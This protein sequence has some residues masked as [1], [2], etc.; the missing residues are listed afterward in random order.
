MD[1]RLQRRIQR[2]GWDLAAGDYEA[3]W[4]LQLAPAQSALMDGAALRYGERVLDV[5]CGTGLVTFA[6]ARAVGAAGEVVGVDISGQMVEAARRARE[7]LDLP[8]VE[9]ARMDAES[10]RFDDASFDVVLCSLGLMYLPD[11]E[12]A[13]REMHRVLRPGGRIA[14]TVWG[15]RAH[16]GWAALFEIVQDE[17]SSDVC[18]MFFRLGQA[19]ALESACRAAGFAVLGAHTFRAPLAYANADEACRA[20]FAGGPVALAWSRFDAQTRASVVARYTQSIAAWRCE[21]AY[22]VP[23]EFSAVVGR[24]I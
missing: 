17:V 8:N 2:Y 3:L 12:Q 24:R 14:L 22:Q 11:P 15:E 10:L 9:F 19:G 21:S 18:P 16:C 13:I 7:G 5:A 23:G 1:A 20:A 6:A 4:R